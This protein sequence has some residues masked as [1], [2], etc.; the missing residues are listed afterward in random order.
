MG[1]AAGRKKLRKG[2]ALAMDS[3]IGRVDDLQGNGPA[4][5]WSMT[6]GLI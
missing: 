5:S 2:V 3:H 6:T 1:G 4:A